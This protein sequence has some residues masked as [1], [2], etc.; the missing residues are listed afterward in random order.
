[1]FETLENGIGL[2]I[3]TALQSTSNPFFDALAKLL[4]VIGGDIGYL[5]LL[6]IIYWSVN[7]R[8]GRQLLFVLLIGLIGNLGL[9]EL[10]DRPRPYVLHPDLV[11]PL[12]LEEGFGMAS[13]HVTL[14]L[15]IW[16][17]VAYHVR[18]WWAWLL[19]AIYILLMAWS[20]MYAG[21][22]Y[23]QDVIVGMIWGG[24]LLWLSLTLMHPAA[25]W[26]RQTGLVPRLV[27]IVVAGLVVGL[28][29]QGDKNGLSTGGIILGGGIG[30]MVEERILGFSADGSRRQ[31][32]LRSAAGLVVALMIFFGLS[33]AFEP[34]TPAEVW[35][36]IR[37]ALVSFA[38]IFIWPWISASIG[39]ST[40]NHPP[41]R[42]K[43]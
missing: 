6:P 24:F 32:I 26:W 22:H 43:S 23:P 31:R 41:Q 5:L 10:L 34:L 1:M 29:L 27:F 35:R 20:R 17:F 3:V 40:A 37:Y 28:L 42:Q 36:V 14:S 9:K 13:T 11:T 16:G 25:R 21:V 38:L 4:N 19:L 2:Q 8:M 7:R 15:I 12:F 18:S 33:F 30:L 39:L